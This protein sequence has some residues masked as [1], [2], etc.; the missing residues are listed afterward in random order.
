MVALSLAYANW[1]GWLA[2]GLLVR[3][4]TG[5]ATLIV[6]RDAFPGGASKVLVKQ[7]GKVVSVIDLN[8]ANWANLEPGVYQLFAEGVWRGTG[9]MVVT[10]GQ[11]TLAAGERLVARV[12][13]IP[14]PVPHV[15]PIPAN[16]IPADVGTLI[17][18]FEPG[19]YA[20]KIRRFGVVVQARPAGAGGV[21]RLVLKPGEQTA[22]G[23]Q[24]GDYTLEINESGELE[25][26][27]TQVKLAPKAEELITLR[28][29][30]ALSDPVPHPRGIP[31]GR[32]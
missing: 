13:V 10:P 8:R 15:E 5:R 6:E 24:P 2:P 14:S 28:P 25:L 23:I 4:A 26:S 31:Q 17:L 27:R 12:A 1:I 11:V 22:T 21:T 7:H 19:T 30:S 20:E 18:R 16:E 29:K 32:D 9:S 3:L